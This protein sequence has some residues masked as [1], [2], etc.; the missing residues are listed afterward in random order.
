MFSIVRRGHDVS[1]QPQVAPTELLRCLDSLFY[2]QAAHLGLY[3]SVSGSHLRRKINECVAKFRRNDIFV[4]KP[5]GFEYF[6]PTALYGCMPLLFL[7][8]FCPY[9][10]FM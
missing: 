9:G 10:T 8:I 5:L 6:E 2:K 7:P 1:Q 3:S 4:E